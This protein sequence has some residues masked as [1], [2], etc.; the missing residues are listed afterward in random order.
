MH[1]WFEHG[2]DE[3][4]WRSCVPSCSHN[5]EHGRKCVFVNGRV[6]L[7]DMCICMCV[8][9]VWHVCACVRAWVSAHVYVFVCVLACVYARM[10]DCR[11]AFVCVWMWVGVCTCV[12]LCVCVYVW[13]VVRACDD[14]T[15]PA[16][17]GSGDIQLWALAP[18]AQ[19]NTD[20]S[21]F[22]ACIEMDAY[23]FV[24]PHDDLSSNFTIHLRFYSV[25]WTKLVFITRL[26][27]N[28]NEVLEYK[29]FIFN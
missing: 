2:A 23:I 7:C 26:E 20:A 21:L 10:C 11:C 27:L 18:A 8:T 19:C 5:Q 13:C 24:L 6:V 28:S 9:C 4:G 14:L 16:S 1:P 15:G 29:H 25:S 3:R 12:W 17:T 22:K